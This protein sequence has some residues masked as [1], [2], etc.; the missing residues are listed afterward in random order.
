MKKKTMNIFIFVL[1]IL[2]VLV[3]FYYFN[4]SESY[5]YKEPTSTTTTTT[6][7]FISN[8][9]YPDYSGD[10]YIELNGN[11]PNFSDSDYSTTSIEM[12]SPLDNLGRCGVAY[13]NIGKDLMPTEKRGS[14]SNVKPS[15][16]QSVKYDNVPGKYLYNRCHLIGYQLTGENDNELN[17][18]TC[19]RFMN[20]TTMLYF[21]DLTADYI[22]KTSN[23]VLY[24]VTPIYTG[25]DLVAKGVQM[26][27]SSVE[28]KCSSLRFNVFVYNVQEGIKIDYKT[29]LSERS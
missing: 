6:K 19:T 9:E 29:G 20:A 26:E 14:I 21:E 3:V 13:S 11:I 10:A 27:I 5:A 17:L 28:D 22:K 16:W 4:N 18:I 23:H 24:R 2:L 12:Y 8:G 7:E 1:C 25:D 15:G